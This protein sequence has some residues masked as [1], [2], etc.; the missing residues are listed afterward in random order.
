MESKRGQLTIF[1]VAGVL[2]I[3]A[4][5][6]YFLVRQGIVPS[7]GGGGE[8]NPNS[9]LQSCIEEKINEAVDLISIQGGNIQPEIYKSFKFTN[10]EEPINITY[11]CYNQN[12]FGRCV[13][14]QPLLV[15]HINS[16]IENYIR[17]DVGV[18]INEL[19]KNL[20]KQNYVVTKTYNG[21]EIDLSQEGIVLRIDGEFDLT[22]NDE[23]S[24]LT[25]IGAIISS[26][27]YD[28][29]LVANKIINYEARYCDFN[30]ESYM[31]IYKNI[32]VDLFIDSVGEKIYTVSDRDINRKFRFAVRGCILE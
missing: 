14:Q 27:L 1:V 3:G 19:E 5:A 31:L 25:N 4:I 21:F 29:V 11:L 20:Q 17:E 16:E 22:R 9:F 28:L 18:C 26:N 8:V 2:V 7:I 23:S 24:R 12:T 13:T 10:E 6:F 32:K 30:K 15:E